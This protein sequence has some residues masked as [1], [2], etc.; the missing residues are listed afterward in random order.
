MTFPGNGELAATPQQSP[1]TTH[2]LPTDTTRCRLHGNTASST[3][4]ESAFGNAP[5][6]LTL[7]RPSRRAS[8]RHLPVDP[9]VIAASPIRL[10]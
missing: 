6:L 1:Q 3:S 8:L 7:S 2:W 4:H 10:L 5:V 9:V